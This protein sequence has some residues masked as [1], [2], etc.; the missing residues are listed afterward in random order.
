MDTMV[1]DDHCRVIDRA[2]A[3][4][5][6]LYPWPNTKEFDIMTTEAKVIRYT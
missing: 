4:Q 2:P 5:T 6:A 1:I 3:C